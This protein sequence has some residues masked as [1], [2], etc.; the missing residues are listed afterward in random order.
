MRYI[1]I[2]VLILLIAFGATLL[3]TEKET[4]VSL[5]PLIIDLM[6]IIPDHPDSMKESPNEE[7]EVNIEI[8]A[9][10]EATASKRPEPPLSAPEPLEAA[11]SFIEINQKTREALVNIL[12]TTK[13]AGPFLPTTGSGIIVD[14]RGII[15]TNA[16]LAQY[17]LLKDYRTKDF[18]ECVIRTGSPAKPVYKAEL[19]YIPEAWVAANAGSITGQNHTGTGEDDF[20]LLRIKEHVQQSIALPD[21]FSA[22]S[23]DVSE[24]HIT[25]NAPILI[26]SYPAGFLSGQIVQKD[27]YAL[28]TIASIGELFTFASTTIDIFSTGGNLA[29]QKGSSGGAVMGNHNKLVGLV[30]LSTTGETTAERDLRAITLA[31]INR[32]LMKHT[33]QD[34]ET[35]LAGDLA[36]ESAN[37]NTTIAPE[38]TKLLTDKLDK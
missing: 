30:T 3:F 31:H 11:V 27:L 5:E 28:S 33:G 25:K 6:E 36:Q 23:V 22:V 18:V 32:S 38:L 10:E 15:L 9:P 17:F 13:S 24:S 12:C 29:A 34:L 21:S 8:P 26:A 20:A 14:S 7:K 1:F 2:F 37:F 19:L 35:F 4:T 16:H